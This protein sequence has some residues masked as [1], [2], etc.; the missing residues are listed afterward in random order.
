MKKVSE[1][2]TDG[3]IF[4]DSALDQNLY[5]A[6]IAAIAESAIQRHGEQEWRAVLLATEMHGHLGIY[7]ILGAKMGVRACEL[8]ETNSRIN[9]L[10]Y[11]GKLPPLSCLNDGL[12]A[13]CGSTLGRGLIEV[14]SRHPRVE[15]RFR[16]GHHSLRLRLLPQYQFLI[17]H[18][19]ERC[20]ALYPRTTPKYWQQVRHLALGYWLDLSRLDIFEM[21]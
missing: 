13:G 18:D 2:V 4:K 10:S 3:H 9:T 1:V 21:D 8:L 5:K 12:Q 17:K 15:A 11:A 7:S 19:M 20:T 14:D 6:D 16:H